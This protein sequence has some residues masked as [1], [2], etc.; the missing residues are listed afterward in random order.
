MMIHNDGGGGGSDDDDD[1]GGDGG[2]GD[3]DD[4]DD[5]DNDDCYYFPQQIND[6]FIF[7]QLY[8]VNLIRVPSAPDVIINVF[9]PWYFW[10]LQVTSE[11]T[12][13]VVRDT[14]AAH[15]VPS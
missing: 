1:G 8:Y 2:G 5:H 13:A 14:N 9:I 4:D 3:N 10:T 15:V 12:V 7:S 11:R 6:L